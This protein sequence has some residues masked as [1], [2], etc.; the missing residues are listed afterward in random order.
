VLLPELV[1]S[2]RSLFLL[3]SYI[4]N[5]MLSHEKPRELS[6][7]MVYSFCIIFYAC[8][9]LCGKSLHILVPLWPCQFL[10]S[11]CNI[12]V[13]FTMIELEFLCTWFRNLGVEPLSAN[14]GK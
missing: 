6:N 3:M 11:N 2:R 9:S 8:S 1:L 4:S 5:A 14:I 13:A 10:D 7:S 12:D